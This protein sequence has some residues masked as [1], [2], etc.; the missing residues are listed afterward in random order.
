MVMPTQEQIA[1][2]Q[3]LEKFMHGTLMDIKYHF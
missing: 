3:I 1:Q 2:I